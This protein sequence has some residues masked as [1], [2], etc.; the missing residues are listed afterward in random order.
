MTCKGDHYVV[1]VLTLTFIFYHFSF[2]L[3]HGIKQTTQPKDKMLLLTLI[4]QKVCTIYATF[5]LKFT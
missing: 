4:N 3:L 5:K 2:R 1:R